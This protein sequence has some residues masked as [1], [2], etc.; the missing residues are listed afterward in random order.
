MFCIKRSENNPLIVPEKSRLWE[1]LSTCNGCPIKEGKKITIFYR[2][3]ADPDKMG[4]TKDICASTIA[5]AEST[6]GE[7]FKNQKEFISPEF[8]WEKYGC[9][10]PRITK[11]EGKYYIF[12]TALSTYPF[13]ADGIKVGVAVC[14]SLDEVKE[15]HPVT[16]FNA[17]AMAIFPE[18]INGKVAVILSANTDKPPSEVAVRLMDSPEELW[19][20]KG[21]DEWYKNLDKWRIPLRR[22]ESDQVEVGAPPVKT[23]DGWLLI[24]SHIQNYFSSNKV[25]GIEAVLVDLDNPLKVLGRTMHPFMIPE[26]VYE[27]YGFVQSI[28]FPTGA[29]LEKDNLDIY[30]GAADTTICKA[31]VRLSDLI[32]AIKTGTRMSHIKRHDDNPVLLPFPDHKWESRAVFNPG[33]LD[34]DGTV[35]ILYRAM[36]FDRTSTFGYAESKDGEFITYRD[37]NPVYIPRAEFELKKGDPNGNSGCED[38]RMTVLGDRI[39]VCYTAYDGVQKPRVAVS[40]ISKKD[41]LDRKWN[42]SM[43]IPLTPAGIDDKDACLFPEKV[44]GKYVFIHRVQHVICLNYLDNLDFIPGEVEKC[45]NII[46][47][48]LGMW[49]G[50]KVGLSSIPHKTEKGWLLFYHGI[51][52]VGVYRMGA[53]LLDLEDPT[54]VISRTSDAVFEPKEQYEKF[55]EVPNVVFPCGSVIRGDTVYLYYGGADT[56]TGVAMLSLSHLLK[57]L[58]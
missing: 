54:H 32:R 18:R 8:D 15:K 39:Y 22:N 46:E 56:V 35:R 12:Y 53:V 4:K 26:E 23:K 33:A 47:P 52:S 38:P 20:P 55:G 17:K 41:F 16:T 36:S 42:W 44:N 9:E 5:K 28:V 14:D 49:D 2:A 11:F 29:I 57:I 43:P 45:I 30:Y 13:S 10:D 37:P 21:W 48:R 19:D 7:H 6:D 58:S 34:L 31:S 40:Y 1:E 51:D 3:I 24:Y 25:F 27:H 50:A